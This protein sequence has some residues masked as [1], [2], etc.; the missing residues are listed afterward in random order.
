MLKEDYNVITAKSGELAL[1]ILEHFR[2][3][4]LPDLVLLDVVMPFMDGWEAF[5]RIR[6]ISI[7]K[8]VPIIFL[9]SL[10]EKEE[11]ERAID[12]GAADFIEKPYKRDNLL[13]RIK[14][15][16]DRKNRDIEMASTP[17]GTINAS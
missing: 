14:E 4:I 6:K 5:K 11:H 10:K 16:I 13:K 1:Q 8:E 9:T 2:F 3:G 12:M 15:V 17:N 7:L